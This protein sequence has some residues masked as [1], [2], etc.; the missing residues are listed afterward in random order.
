M[1]YV[2]NSITRYYTCLPWVWGTQYRTDSAQSLYGLWLC[3]NTVGVSAFWRTVH[4]P[5]SDCLCYWSS[6]THLWL[7]LGDRKQRSKNLIRMSQLTVV[8]FAAESSTFPTGQVRVQDLV[9]DLS[10]V[11]VSTFAQL[12]GSNTRVQYMKELHNSLSSGVKSAFG[13]LS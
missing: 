8:I 12:K 13:R 1:Q 2:I 5:T 3:H 10:E 7:H 6:L 4:H 9:L 11:R